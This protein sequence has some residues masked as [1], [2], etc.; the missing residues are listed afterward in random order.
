[1]PCNQLKP[2]ANIISENLSSGHF[3]GFSPAKSRNFQYIKEKD[4]EYY[5]FSSVV[6]GTIYG[7]QSHIITVEVDFSRGLPCFVMVGMVSPEVRESA[8]RVRIALKNIKITLPA[9]HIAVNLS[10]GDIK[11][12]GTGF[13]LP[14]ALGALTNMEI[15]K[16]DALK[17]ILVMGELGLNGE[18][19]KVNGVLP[20]IWEGK[21]HGITQC[22]VPKDNAIEAA[23]IKGVKVVGVE[24]IPEIIDYLNSP[25][26]QKDCL[27]P[28]TQ[29]A[30]NILWDDKIT[31]DFLDVSGQEKLKRGALIA[32]SGFHHMLVMGPP[33]TGK[34]MIAQRMP[35]IM[36][37]LSMEEKMDITSIYS[38]AG[39]L[40]RDN[41]VI[42]TRPFVSVH[43]SV[44]PQGITGGGSVPKPGAVSLAHKGILFLDELPEFQRQSLDMLRQP[45]E[46][47]KI[48]I[49]RTGGIFTYPADIMLVAAMNPCPCGYYPDVDKCNCTPGAIR[50]YLGHISG[51]ILDRMDICITAEK[52]KIRD[53]QTK[54]EGKV[55]MSTSEMLD[56]VI[57]ARKIQS[58]R[59]CLNSY[60]G[61]AEIKQYCSLGTKEKSLM[62]KAGEKLGIS[63]RGYF[64]TL[65]V[66]RTIADLNNEESI[67]EDHLIEALSYRPQL[68]TAE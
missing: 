52:I 44:S 8:E 59:P 36:P 25:E 3:T 16:K 18:V 22:L 20:I 10:P 34:T 56:K 15:I 11:K 62:E 63:A 46:E 23:L 57:S 35:G 4:E 41:P 49:V 39:K 14:L 12:T 58:G 48:N 21:K 28:P 55:G 13:D 65:K 17:D 53:L 40:T 50:H 33:G 43:H 60:M 68:P 2:H 19:K 26:E 7:M 1:M 47:K 32:A 51:P 5:M 31:H 61:V 45:L 6:S 67:K 66:A 9:M 37:P 42:R 54:D 24:N 30:E 27:I 64:R 38:I 29:S